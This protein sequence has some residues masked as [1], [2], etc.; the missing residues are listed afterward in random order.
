MGK[1]TS[2]LIKDTG[3]NLWMAVSSTCPSL[4]FY[5]SSSLISDAKAVCRQR[6]E[7]LPY[8]CLEYDVLLEREYM[9]EKHWVYAIFMAAMESLPLLYQTCT[10]EEILQCVLAKTYLG[11]SSKLLDNLND[12]IHTVDEA[13]NSLENYLNALMYGAYE[14]KSGSPVEMAETSACEM[15][16]WIYQCLDYDA[17]AFDLYKKDCVKLV[18]GQISSLEHKS[19]EWPL[20]K[21]YVDYI[22]EKSIGDVWVDIDLCQTDSLDEELLLL[23]K[24]NEYIFKS[25]LVYDDVQDLLED[26]QTKSVNSVLILALERGVITEE[27]CEKMAP[28]Q[29][30]HVLERTGIVDDIIHLADAFF[31]KGVFVLKEMETSRVDMKGLFQSFRLVRLFNLRKLLL[32]KKDVK[33]FKKVLESFSD[34]RSLK[35]RIPEEIGSLVW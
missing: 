13:L 30:V 32:M 23:K 9:K 19:T 33:T 18:E 6:L 1:I 17:P 4:R 16:S 24:G 15:A 21:D 29:L 34:F 14:R 27:D 11:T 7:S 12:E 35:N 3:I 31:L 10:K 28:A 20:L 26:I 25:S 2:E 8:G 22:A 5:V